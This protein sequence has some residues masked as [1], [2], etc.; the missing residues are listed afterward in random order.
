MPCQIIIINGAIGQQHTRG[1]HGGCSHTNMK[2]TAAWRDFLR[3]P[4]H[5]GEK[6]SASEVRQ[7]GD[8]PLLVSEFGNWGLPDVTKLYEGNNGAVTLVVR[9]R[10]GVG[11]WRRIPARHRTA[12]QG[13]S[14]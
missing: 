11:R 2:M 4:W 7:R 13:L 9:Y 12:L 1:V 5:T 10:A 6:P 8:E 3:D 14:S